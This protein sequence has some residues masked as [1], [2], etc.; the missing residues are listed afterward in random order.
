MVQGSVKLSKSS[1]SS[2]SGK[3]KMSGK[4]LKQLKK[5]KYTKVGATLKL[6]KNGNKY[7]DKALEDRFV[8]KEIGKQAEQRTAA[9]LI[10]GGGKMLLKDLVQKGKELNK[11]TRRSQVKKKL[12]R[13]EEKLKELENEAQQKGL[14]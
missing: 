13:V 2:G 11:E 9:K 8:S 5:D 6:P 10:Q 1:S 14:V 12:G 4:L 3:M 7:R